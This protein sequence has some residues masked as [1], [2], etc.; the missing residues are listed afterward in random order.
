MLQAMLQAVDPET[1]QQLTR[2]EQSDELINV[3]V[4]DVLGCVRAFLS[5][6]GPRNRLL[7]TKA[8][9]ICARGRCTYCRCI[10]TFKS[11]LQTKLPRLV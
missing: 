2:E 4:S 7:D 8:L 11:D 9:Q 5:C 3:L 10:L 1:K 6:S